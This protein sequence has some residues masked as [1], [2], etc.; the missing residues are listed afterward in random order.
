MRSIAEV[1]KATL[2][3]MKW[4]KAMEKEFTKFNIKN[5]DKEAYKLEQQYANM[6]IDD[7]SKSQQLFDSLVSSQK[8]YLQS[9]QGK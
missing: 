9:L 7:L 2:K 6:I 5:T 3:A 8:Y 1:Q 4:A